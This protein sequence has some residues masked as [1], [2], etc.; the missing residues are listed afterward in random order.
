MPG[1]WLTLS[2]CL[3]SNHPTGVP[4]SNFD[5]DDRDGGGGGRTMYLGSSVHLP[6]ND[7]IK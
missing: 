1:T 5:D 3:R 4:S 2:N 6:P 7:A